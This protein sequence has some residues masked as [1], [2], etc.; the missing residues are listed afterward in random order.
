MSTI[1][2]KY[3]LG[4]RLGL[5]AGMYSIAGAFAGLIAYGIFQIKNASLHNWQLLFIIEGALSVFMA[6]VTV[7]VLPARLES[8]WCMSNEPRKLLVSTNYSQS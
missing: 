2:P 8:A 7:L 3:S 4:L 1:Y 6:V 5:F